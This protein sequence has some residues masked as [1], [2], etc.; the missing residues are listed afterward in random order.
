MQPHERIKPSLQQHLLQY[1]KPDAAAE[2]G[3]QTSVAD[4]LNLMQHL[5]PGYLQVMYGLVKSS[6]VD[7]LVIWQR[8]WPLEISTD[9]CSQLLLIR[10]AAS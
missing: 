7:G 6:Q 8:W 5:G 10:H 1:M 3:C 4:A 2:K 9:I